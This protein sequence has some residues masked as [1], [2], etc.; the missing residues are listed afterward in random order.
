ME[1][2]GLSE[3]LELFE[4]KFNKGNGYQWKVYTGSYDFKRY[5]PELN[6]ALR[7]GRVRFISRKRNVRTYGMNKCYSY[8]LH[9]KKH[10]L[11]QCEACKLL[12]KTNEAL[13]LKASEIKGNYE[14][15]KLKSPSK[16]QQI[17]TILKK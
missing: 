1:S 15:K 11:I 17:I 14:I 6:E 3:R 12:Q 13:L 7:V 16:L 9:L 5:L 2:L 4:R 10:C 8:E